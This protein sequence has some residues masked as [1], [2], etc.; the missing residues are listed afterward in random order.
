MLLV[1][2]WWW[3]FEG[4]EMLQGYDDDI[5]RNG[6]VFGKPERAASL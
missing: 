4:V 2:V 3:T 1:Y 5:I 6:Q